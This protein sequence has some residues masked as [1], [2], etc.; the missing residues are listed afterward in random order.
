MQDA[1]KDRYPRSAAGLWFDG[2]GSLWVGELGGTA[3]AFARTAKRRSKAVQRA[4]EPRVRPI[5][6]GR[7]QPDG[8]SDAS[9]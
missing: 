9:F 8:S 6:I 2:D 1:E 4:A 3:V 7:F 5:K